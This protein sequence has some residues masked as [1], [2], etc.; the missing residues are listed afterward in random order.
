MVAADQFLVDRSAVSL[1]KQVVKPSIKRG[2]RLRSETS[3]VKELNKYRPP[4]RQI[5]T[6]MDNPIEKQ[7]LDEPYDWN[8]DDFKEMSL[9]VRLPHCALPP[10]LS[11]CTLFNKCS[12]AARPPDA[13]PV[14][15][16]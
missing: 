9:Q 6:T 1:I 15:L 7:A 12:S 2:L 14:K 16:V 5:P 3:S 13:R 8:F 4:D 11:S 10:I